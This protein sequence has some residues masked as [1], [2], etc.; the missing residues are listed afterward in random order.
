MEKKFDLYWCP[1]VKK[2]YIHKTN[3]LAPQV[4]NFKLKIM[5][6][7]GKQIREFK[8]KISKNENNDKFMR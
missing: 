6:T 4:C 1:E 5:A 7:V 3:Y 8:W 2:L